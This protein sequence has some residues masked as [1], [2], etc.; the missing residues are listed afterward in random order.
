MLRIGSMCAF[1][2]LGACV[3]GADA[4]S[5]T[6]QALS[7]IQTFS[8]GTPGNSGPDLDLGPTSDRTCFLTGIKGSLKGYA[9]PGWTPFVHASAGVFMRNG[10]WKVETRAGDGP[11]VEAD[12]VCVLAT[13]HRAT[14]GVSSALGSTSLPLG[15][16]HDR[17]CFINS[18]E[19]FGFGFAGGLPQF[20]GEFPGAIITRDD[21]AGTW[22]MGGA[23]VDNPDSSISG[24]V[25]AV[26][27][28]LPT[29]QV[30]NYG[31]TAG[32]GET[33]KE[34]FQN[35]GSYAC[36][37]TGI[38]GAFMDDWNHP[39]AEVTL[40]SANNWTFDISSKREIH[41]KCFK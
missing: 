11:G 16:D 31:W 10:R 18:I 1:T 34:L 26:C 5:E 28:D 40:D 33:V 21:P 32:T 24:S 17:K 9:G 41:V 35:D 20:P 27:V 15:A 12:G 3:A 25:G 19:A 36:G 30:T 22:D 29:T 37:L 13:G 38:F 6:D 2:L 4:T 14:M 23:F 8:W 39:G 7:F